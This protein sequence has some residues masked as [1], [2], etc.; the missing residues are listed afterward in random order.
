MTKVRPV[1]LVEAGEERPLIEDVKRVKGDVRVEHE[2]RS[3]QGEKGNKRKEEK[4]ATVRKLEEKENKVGRKLEEKE[5][6]VG[7]KLEEKENRVGRK[8]EQV[9]NSWR[10]SVAVAPRK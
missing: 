5:N 10:R 3:K 7:R 4:E 6:K 9:V 8:E 2:Q 1:Q